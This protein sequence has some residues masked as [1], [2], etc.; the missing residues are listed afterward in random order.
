[1]SETLQALF[2]EIG[3]HFSSKDKLLEP[4]DAQFSQVFNLA[5]SNDFWNLLSTFSYKFEVA[6]QLCC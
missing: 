4:H 1:M 2:P 6:C 3:L 5:R